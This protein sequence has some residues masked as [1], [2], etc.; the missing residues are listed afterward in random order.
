MLACRKG[1]GAARSP[2]GTEDI[3]PSI[4][5]DTSLSREA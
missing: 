1:G 2:R 3:E 5:S 4:I